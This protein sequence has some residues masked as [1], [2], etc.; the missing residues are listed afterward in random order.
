MKKTLF[1]ISTL[2][3]LLWMGYLVLP[4]IIVQQITDFEPHTFE[5]VLNDSSRRANYGIGMNSKPE[6]YGFQSEEI[7]FQSFDGIKLNSWYIPCKKPS[8]RSI[9]F[10]HGRTSN[11]L[12]TM[13]YLA[14]I[15]SLDLDTMYN[16][17]I[18]DLRN[19]GRSQAS[20]TFMGYKFAEEKEDDN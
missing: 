1:I 18:P 15:D 17:F 5:S 11:R 9:V 12:K 6:D 19:S 10:V 7:N 20:E 3:V 4:Y 14:L 2:L 8:N 16:V 13:T